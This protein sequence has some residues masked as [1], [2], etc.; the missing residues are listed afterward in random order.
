MASCGAFVV[1]LWGSDRRYS[2]G[3]CEL[4]IGSSWRCR[5]GPSGVGIGRLSGVAGYRAEGLGW[6][7]VGWARDRAYGTVWALCDSP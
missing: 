3:P 1:G 5:E 7:H 2:M 4:A 6:A